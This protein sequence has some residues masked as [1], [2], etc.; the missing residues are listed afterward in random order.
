MHWID[1]L[2]YLTSVYPLTLA[3]W[4]NRRTT[5][6]HALS[7]TLAAW[8]CWCGCFLLSE[9]SEHQT[10][11]YLALCL[12]GCAGT[13]VLGAR[14]PIVGAWNLVLIGLLAV[15]LLPL[16][17]HAVLG[18]GLLDPLRLIFVAGTLSVGVLNYLPT[19]LA[20]PMLVVGLVSAGELFVLADP[21]G[22]A[23]CQAFL[24]H[25]GPLLLAAACWIGWA[26]M[27]RPDQSLA[28]FD[29]IWLAFRDRF[30]LMWGQRVR[31]QFNQAAKN[32][33]WPV[34]LRW[35][36]LRRTSRD[37]PLP[38]ATQ[39]IIVDAMRAMLRRFGEPEERS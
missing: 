32:A 6:L 5:L 10:A 13:A 20:V 3:W 9:G 14:R 22:A 31:E 1:N 39:T 29:Q 30:G 25:A 19:R 11:R 12:T 33:D 28:E 4:S 27:R 7:W 23:A 17:E 21:E 36:G 24:V 18:T 16:G 8:T 35:S 2:V 34:I 38:A 15:L 37:R 26:L